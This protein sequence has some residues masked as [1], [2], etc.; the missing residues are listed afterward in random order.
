MTSST[1]A[2]VS[3]I[4]AAAAVARASGAGISSWTTR[5]EVPSRSVIFQM[6]DA[7]KTRLSSTA[8]TAPALVLV[9]EPG[10]V[11]PVVASTCWR[12][13]IMG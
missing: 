12:V 5:S 6:P 8:E 11:D 3:A 10:P 1:P 7:R 2:K 4:A 9:R 13:L